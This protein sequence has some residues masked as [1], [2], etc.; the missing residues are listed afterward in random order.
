MSG[1]TGRVEAHGT[2]KGP[3]QRHRPDQLVHEQYKRQ[4]LTSAP[5][6]FF[7]TSSAFFFFAASI[8]CFSSAS[9]RALNS[10]ILSSAPA[11]SFSVCL[12]HHTNGITYKGIRNQGIRRPRCT[13][14]LRTL[15]NL[16]LIYYNTLK[17]GTRLL[18]Q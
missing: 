4:E 10:A 12:Q 9:F 13:S 6:R 16:W 18:F 2:G 11:R 15:T 3:R 5:A 8:S 17:C 7:S 1:T 14:G